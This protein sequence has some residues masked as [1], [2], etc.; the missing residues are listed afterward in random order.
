MTRAPSPVPPAPDLAEAALLARL[1]ALGIGWTRHAHPPQHTVDQSRALRG[2]LP[3]AH[4]KNLFLIDRDGA[5]WLVTCAEDRRFR[6]PDLARA[7]GA[8]RLSF[9]PPD[10]LARHLRVAPG[11]VTPLALMHDADRAVR[12]I[13]DP[14]LLAAEIFNC[15][16]LHN[17][18]TLAISSL[19]LRRF[20]TATGHA[21]ILADFDAVE[22]AHPA[23]R[24]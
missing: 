8:P 24:P 19:D 23:A 6:I 11:A 3:G 16:P 13:L 5:P 14:V 18:A 1:D 4:C 9:A 2:A 22:A 17:A 7:V 21:P 20:L 12:L 15:H 10:L